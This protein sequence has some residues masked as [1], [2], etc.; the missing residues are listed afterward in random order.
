MP[1]NVLVPAG[2]GGLDRDSVIN[3]TQLQTVDKSDLVNRIGRLPL[4]VVRDIDGGL[5]SALEL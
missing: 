3:V 2:T 1:G 5:R 4:P